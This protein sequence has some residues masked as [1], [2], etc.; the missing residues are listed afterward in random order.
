MAVV[1]L[2]EGGRHHRQLVEV[3]QLQD[4]DPDDAEE[5]VDVVRVLQELPDDLRKA[6]PGHR[7]FP[8][9]V[10]RPAWL[11]PVARGSARVTVAAPD[12][13]HSMAF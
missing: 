2:H 10:P 7:S 4:L 1:A 3:D 5:V 13:L 6:C 9:G 8:G 11:Q 12:P